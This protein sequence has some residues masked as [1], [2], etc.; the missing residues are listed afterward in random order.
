MQTQYPH[1]AHA[2]D[3]E[4]VERYGRFATQYFSKTIDGGWPRVFGLENLL[5]IPPDASVVLASVHKSHIDYLLLPVILNH[6]GLPQPL[7]D[8][9]LRPVAIAA[10]DNL[11]G[12]IGKWDFG[13]MLRNAGA[14]KIIRQASAEQRRRV[15]ED[16]QNYTV[17]R[18]GAG[19]WFI[20]FPERGRSYTGEIK[21]F[22]T[23]SIGMFLRAETTTQRPVRFVPVSISYERVAEDKF[24]PIL[25]KHRKRRDLAYYSLDLPMIFAQQYLAQLNPHPL[26][27]VIVRFGKP[28]ASEEFPDSKKCRKDQLTA[29]LEKDCRSLTKALPTALFATALTET[30]D[31]KEAFKRIMHYQ[32]GLDLIDAVWGPDNPRS[33]AERAMRFFDRPF[34]RFVKDDGDSYIVLRQDVI[35]YYANTI[36]HL[37]DKCKPNGHASPV[38]SENPAKA[39]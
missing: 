3:P 25:D 5:S 22:D 26:G 9:N 38:S 19:D 36:K 35:A 15:L 7:P 4:T 21:R 1:I 6:S 12:R 17:E 16:Q 2:Y 20:I 28:I 11:F 24:F 13:R 27:H 18:V 34:R 8:G 31:R 29:R 23:A 10:G 39:F 14:Y 33:I 32:T 30:Q 37:T